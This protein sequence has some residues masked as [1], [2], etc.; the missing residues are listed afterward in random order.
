M[1]VAVEQTLEQKQALEMAATQQAQLLEEFESAR[2]ELEKTNNS[3]TEQV[4]TL[5]REAKLSSVPMPVPAASGEVVAAQKKLEDQLA[6]AN[7][8]LAEAKDE[9]ARISMAESMQRM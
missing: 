7:A 8:E 3:L 6:K 9:L 2:Q 5:K 1:Q 4:E